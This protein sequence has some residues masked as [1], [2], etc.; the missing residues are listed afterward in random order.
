MYVKRMSRVRWVVAGVTLATLLGAAPA[1]ASTPPTSSGE[2]TGTTTGGGDTSNLPDTIT[3]GSV[4]SLTGPAAF[5][6]IN[7]VDGMNLAIQ[8]A[9]EQGLLGDSTVELQVADD[10]S[11]AEGGVAAYRQLA[12]QGVSAFVGPCFSP[13]AQAVI[14]LTSD[15]EIPMVLTTA[16]GADFAE[17]EWAYRAGVPQTHYVGLVADALS[18]K[19]ITSVSVIYQ[20]DNEAIVDLWNATLKPRLEELGIEILFEDAVAGNTQ[21]FSAQIAQY[22]DNPPDAIGILMVGG[23]NVTAVTQV[24]EAGLEQPL[25][26]QQAMA[27]PFFLENAGEAADG[28]IF[29]ANFHPGFEF[30]SSQA[31]TEAFVAEYGHDPDYAAAN[32]YD[33]MMRVLLAINAAG[34]AE[35]A[36]IKAALD[37][38]IPSM[39]G[40]QGPLTFTENGDVEAPG[41]VIEVQYPETV[42][43][44]TGEG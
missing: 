10:L 33:A 11:T 26:G 42:T 43:I 19:G 34:S 2:E 4:N 35:P 16:G 17:P 3:I 20:N 21:D 18:D 44:L 23:A 13:S 27:A 39:D 12:D 8:V 29:N 9:T 22:S 32:G 28:T 5:C 24:R 25:F 7:E 37:N 31:F 6:G 41:G 15:D 40:A 14:T 30:P 38:D 36:D 1:V